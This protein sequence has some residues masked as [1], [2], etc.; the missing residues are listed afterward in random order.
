MVASWDF[1]KQGDGAAG[2]SASEQREIHREGGPE[3]PHGTVESIMN[4]NLLILR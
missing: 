1:A 3:R 2:V 4:I